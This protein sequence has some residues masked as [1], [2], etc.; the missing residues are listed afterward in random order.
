MELAMFVFNAFTKAWGT[1]EQWVGIGDGRREADVIVPVQN[2][3]GERLAEIVSD[4]DRAGVTTLQNY[5]REL[6]MMSLQFQKFLSDPQFTDG[7]AS[8]Q[9]FNDIIPLIA[10]IQ[11]GIAQ[12]IMQ[13]GG[14]I[15]LTPTVTQGAGYILPRLSNPSQTT[16]PAIPQAGTIWPNAPLPTIRSTGVQQVAGFDPIS[17]LVIG[18]LALTLLKKGRR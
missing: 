9:A 12:R 14:S 10:N 5:H 7:R 15:P 13:R 11:S 16:F 3:I 2:A 18:G 1:I 4:Q 8:K 17:M 6:G